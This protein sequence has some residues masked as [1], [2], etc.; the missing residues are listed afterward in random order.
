[1]SIKIEKV[2]AAFFSDV[3][4]YDEKYN[5]LKSNKHLDVKSLPF[6]IRS[7]LYDNFHKVKDIN[8]NGLK[9]EKK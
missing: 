3:Y 6:P 8:E 4:T 1:M 5:E 7:F 9:I 2:L